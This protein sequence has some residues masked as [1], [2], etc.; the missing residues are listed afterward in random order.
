MKIQSIDIQRLRDVPTPRPL[1]PAWSPGTV[2]TS[3]SATVIRMRTDD[4]AEGFGTGGSPKALREAADQLIG[5]DPFDMEAHSRVL[6]HNGAAW[7]ME[8]A[9]WDVIGKV[10]N[11][12]LFKLWGGFA[13][14]VPG[15][16]SMVE[17]VSIDETV[18]RVCGLVSEGF[19]AVKIRLHHESMRDD[20][21]LAAAIRESVG[22]RVGLMADANQARVPFAPPG[23]HNPVWDLRRARTTAI[24]LQ[25]LDYLWLE[26]PLGRYD[27]AGLAA[28]NTSVDIAIAGGEKNVF[29]H[30][31]SE[32]IDRG[33]YDIVQPDA[34]ISEGIGQLRKVASYAEM[35]RKQCIPHHGGG[36]IGAYGHL[37]LAAAIPNAGWVEVLRDRAGEFPWPAQLVVQK[38]LMVDGNGAVRLPTE[39]GL[40]IALDEAFI[41]RYVH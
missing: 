14:Q 5:C 35:H 17:A 25:E 7:G 4:G 41:N 10:C 1:R 26:E 6:R 15:Y 34:L 30:E 38:P 12:P 16:A 3:A 9:L 20:I 40:G 13:N 39:P 27:Y 36:G 29:L 21:A 28:L 11:Q 32:L 19:T 31:F 2:K 33:C 24:A 18:E 22:P 23:E 8:L 37:H